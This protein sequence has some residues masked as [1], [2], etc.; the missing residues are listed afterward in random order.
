MTQANFSNPI[1]RHTAFGLDHGLPLIG[2]KLVPPRSAGTVLARTRLLEKVS[3]MQE[4]CMALVCGPAG[5]GKTTLLGQ[6]R[7]HLLEQGHSVAWLSLDQ[8]DN[9]PQTFR[10]YVLAA[11]SQA[12]GEPL[13]PVAA[14]TES[15]ALADSRFIRELINLMQPRQNALYLV[16]DDLHL[17]NH[18]GIVS[19]L[20]QLL[21]HA[22]DCFHLLVGSRSVPALPLSRLQAHNQLLEIDTNALRFNVE[23]TQSYLASA[24][25][26]RFP[27]TELQR[28][29]S[30]TEGWI[31]GIQMAALAPS[32][33]LRNLNRM[34]L[35]SRQIGRYLY[36]VVL[37]PL[38]VR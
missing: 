33:P 1:E 29:L 31:T 36:D 19:D 37:A 10:R 28:V 2:T 32:D 17:L 6:W 25:P 11:L 4:R 15:L 12:S 21:Q 5:F 7:Q 14:L 16:L 30:L 3:L 9:T 22:P 8:Q 20:E 38:P 23:E 27:A 35:G 34:H 24:N 13:E 26:Q 18:P